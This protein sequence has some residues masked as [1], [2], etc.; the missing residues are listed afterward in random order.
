MPEPKA[1]VFVVDDDLSVREALGSLIRAAGLAVRTFASAQEFLACSREETPSCL[2]LDV[3][4]P[5][6][7]GLDLQQRMAEAGLD[8]PII[9]I[10]G[11]GDVPTSVRAMK[12]GAIEFLTKPVSDE[13]LLAAIQDA[14]KRDRVARQQRSEIGRLR[15]RYESLT[16]RE[17]EVMGWVVSGL[18]NKQVAGELGT[19]EVTVKVHRG[20]VM[21]KMQAESLA[22]LVKMAGVLGIA[23]AKKF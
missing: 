6:L 22:D 4:L 7:S 5:G 12:A 10:T 23:P 16:P 1:I 9:F 20:H 19:S 11:H 14:I 18:L 2:I 21:H 3:R 13:E 17:R 8:I 15:T